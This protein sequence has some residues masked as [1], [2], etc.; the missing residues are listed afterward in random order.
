MAC[1]IS[2]C[3]RESTPYNKDA[4]ERSSIQLDAYCAATQPECPVHRCHSGL[5]FKKRYGAT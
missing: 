2:S 1:C 4:Y 3:S 5:Y